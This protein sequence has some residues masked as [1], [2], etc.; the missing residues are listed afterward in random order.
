MQGLFFFL[1]FPL[2]HS[3]GHTCRDVTASQAGHLGTSQAG[4]VDGHQPGTAFEVQRC[5]EY[6]SYF[7]RLLRIRLE[8]SAISI[9]RSETSTAV[10]PL[11]ANRHRFRGNLSS[12]LLRS[13]GWPGP[14]VDSSR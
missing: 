9:L 12:I 7:L 14:A 6:P 2:T 10:P 5:G 1:A 3:D 8:S 11:H 4:R 13:L